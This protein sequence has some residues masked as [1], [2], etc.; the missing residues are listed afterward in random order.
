MIV[1]VDFAAVLSSLKSHSS[2]I[3]EL[4]FIGSRAGGGGGPFGGGN[5]A[6]R[7]LGGTSSV[8]DMIKS[9]ERG[10]LV[11]RFWYNRM[12][13]PRSILATGLTRD[14]TFAIEGG[15]ISHALKNLR[16]NDSPL[17]LLRNVV[18]M[19]RPQRVETRGDFVRLIDWQDAQRNEFLAAQQFTIKG[20]R[21][22]RRPDI[23]L[24][25]YIYNN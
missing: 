10:I 4:S 5:R 21:H 9:T 6:L 23:I 17:T 14:G 16:Y 19:G 22:T 11:T 12:L 1:V 24:F 15:K 18:A 8:A 20:P 2:R 25:I 13:E 3:R 7:M